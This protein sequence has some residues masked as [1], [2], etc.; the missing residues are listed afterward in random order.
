VRRARRLVQ[1]GLQVRTGQHGF[2]YEIVWH[3]AV[4]WLFGS[5]TLVFHRRFAQPT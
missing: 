4:S 2:A 3:D 1:G 5:K